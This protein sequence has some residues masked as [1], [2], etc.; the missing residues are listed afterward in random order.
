M[1]SHVSLV[2]NLIFDIQL[3]KQGSEE[4]EETIG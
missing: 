3:N 1:F 2:Q 4:S